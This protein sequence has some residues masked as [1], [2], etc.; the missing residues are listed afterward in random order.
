MS[1][2]EFIRRKHTIKSETRT[3]ILFDFEN[4]GFYIPFA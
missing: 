4:F 1:G 3:V 2:M